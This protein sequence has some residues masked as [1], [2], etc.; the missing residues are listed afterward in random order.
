MLD[1][2]SQAMLLYSM[3]RTYS[4]A[5]NC[6]KGMELLM[7][8]FNT[9]LC[10]FEKLEEDE[11]FEAL[12]SD[13]RFLNLIEAAK[14]VHFTLKLEESEPENELL[15]SSMEKACELSPAYAYSFFLLA[16]LYAMRNLP[17]KAL[18]SLSKA[19]D[20]GYKNYCAIVGDKAFSALRAKEEFKSL[21]RK[22]AVEKTGG[23]GRDAV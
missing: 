22:Q 3:A 14:L 12:R 18:A 9:G 21:F 20:S 4:R 17:E 11:S 23:Q 1:P 6:D 19:V 8:A 2:S 15:V 10:C 7:K 16:R 13:R 5:G